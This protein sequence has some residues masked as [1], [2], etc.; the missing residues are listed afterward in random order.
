MYMKSSVFIWLVMQCKCFGKNL[1]NP[2]GSYQTILVKK[3]DKST[4]FPDHWDENKIKSEI[5]FA[6]SN[7]KQIGNTEQWIGI[8]SEGIIIEGYMNLITGKIKT[9]Y[10]KWVN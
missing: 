4:F 10:P 5:E 8:S 2:D 3:R 9:A 7:K 1:K 6:Y